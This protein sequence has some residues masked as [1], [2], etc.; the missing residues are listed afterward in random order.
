MRHPTYL[1]N[2]LANGVREQKAGAAAATRAQQA[3]A[4]AAAEDGDHGAA[5]A[6]AG[7]AGGAPPSTR[8]PPPPG[9]RAPP[10]PTP[11]LGH[12]APRDRPPPVPRDLPPASAFAGDLPSLRKQMRALGVLSQARRAGK[13]ARA[14]TFGQGN[15]NYASRPDWA[16]EGAAFDAQHIQHWTRAQVERAYEALRAELEKARREDDAKYGVDAGAGGGGGGGSLPPAA[17][18]AAGGAAGGGV[19]ESE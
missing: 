13:K 9:R 14:F 17:A 19:T 3:A 10:A 15:L 18:A 1:K 2:L 12:V 11:P 7:A 16:P 5:A 8:S 6:A 4:T